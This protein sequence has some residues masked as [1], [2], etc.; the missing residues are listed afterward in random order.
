VFFEF[1]PGTYEKKRRKT[2]TVGQNVRIFILT[3]PQSPNSKWGKLEKKTLLW[4]PAFLKFAF[5]TL[6]RHYF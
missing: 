3:L 4:Y 6:Q 2:G 1:F 5:E